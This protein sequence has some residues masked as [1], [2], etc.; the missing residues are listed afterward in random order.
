MSDDKTTTTEPV[1]SVV[2]SGRS[3]G[4]K[5]VVYD[6]RT[7]RL[8]RYIEKRKVPKVPKAHTLSKKT[9]K[10]FPQ[11]GMMRNDALGCCTIA[12]LAHAEQTW[13]AYGGKPRRPSDAEIVEAYNRVNDG[14]DQGAAMLDV[15]NMARKVG[16]GGNTIYAYVSLDPLNHDQVRTAHFLFGGLYLG[17]NLPVSAQGQ[18]IWDVGEG[19]AFSPGSWGGHAFNAVDYDEKGLT[20]VTWGDLQRITWAWLDRYVDEAYVVLEE[21]Y[22][23]ED[24]RSPQGFSLAKLAA[25]LRVL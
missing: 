15:L 16:I 4:K 23:G 6:P 7:L 22:V 20:I 21:D 5:P 19:P 18:K 17:A 10:A 25:D 9:L 1:P 11:L 8:A 2:A 14:V 3:L 13:S 12:A 24:R